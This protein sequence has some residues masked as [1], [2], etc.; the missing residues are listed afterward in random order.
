MSTIKT[1]AVIE[2]NVNNKAS[3]QKKIGNDQSVTT[4]SLKSKISTPT[5]KSLKSE[6]K[7][8]LQKCDYSSIELETSEILRR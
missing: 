7:I 6:T 3:T 1:L 8:P 2:R 5:T 4:L